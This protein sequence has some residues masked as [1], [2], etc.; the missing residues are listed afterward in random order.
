MA[1]NPGTRSFITDEAG[2]VSIEGED[3]QIRQEVRFH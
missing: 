2:F 3:T 1:L